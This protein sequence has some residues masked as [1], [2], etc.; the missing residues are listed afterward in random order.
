MGLHISSEQL[1]EA[2]LDERGALIEFACRL[3]QAGKLA[4]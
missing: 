1:R 2:G 4:L 3:F